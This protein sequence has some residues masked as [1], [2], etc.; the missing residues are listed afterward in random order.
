MLVQPTTN[1]QDPLQISLSLRFSVT[2]APRISA[3]QRGD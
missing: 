3:R 2:L 1:V